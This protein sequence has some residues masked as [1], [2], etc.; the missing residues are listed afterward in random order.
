MDLVW[1][2]LTFAARALRRDRVP[3]AVAVACLALAMA[4]ATTMF[5]V[6][7]AVIFR[8]LPC[9]APDQLVVVSERHPQRGLM[10]V[11]PANFADW[12]GRAHAFTAV[13]PAIDVTVNSPDDHRH[14]TARLVGADFFRTWGVPPR[15]GRAFAADDYRRA[16]SGDFFGQRGGVVVISNAYWQSRYGGDAAVLG[17]FVRLDSSAYEV[18]GVMPA[19]FAV[20]A[21]CSREWRKPRS[22]V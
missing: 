2:E 12:R 10:A 5:A 9:P 8:P 20:I 4:A 14:L 18:V 13:S 16:V 22:W 7:D 21:W 19:S 11:R 17:R 3:A 6:A 15:L 1:K